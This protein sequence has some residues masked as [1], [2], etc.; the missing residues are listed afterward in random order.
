V[1]SGGARAPVRFAQRLLRGGH[2]GGRRRDADR[3]GEHPHSELR[4]R[5]RPGELRLEPHW[6]Q[7]E[8]EGVA[9]RTDDLLWGLSEQRGEAGDRILAQLGVRAARRLRRLVGRRALGP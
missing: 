4:P 1:S 8:R 3:V 9:E 5:A 2:R 6:Q 7:D